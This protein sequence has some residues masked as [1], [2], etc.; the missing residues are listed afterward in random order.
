MVVAR[1][2]GEAAFVR[3]RVSVPPAEIGWNERVRGR[4][5]FQVEA[6]KQNLITAT[7][8]RIPIAAVT[9]LA[10]S[11]GL[12]SPLPPGIGVEVANSPRLGPS[13]S[14]MK[15]LFFFY[16]YQSCVALL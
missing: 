10:V 15:A 14:G 12:A 6:V 11:A 9:S 7:V 2:D 8:R 1:G 3:P 13:L 16:V 5:S 4:G